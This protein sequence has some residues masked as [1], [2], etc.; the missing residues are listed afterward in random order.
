MGYALTTPYLENRDDGWQLESND[1]IGLLIM[2]VA[3]EF[4][5]LFF[6]KDS[7]S[8]KISFNTNENK[9]IHPSHDY[10]LSLFLFQKIQTSYVMFFSVRIL[11]GRGECKVEI[12]IEFA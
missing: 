4:I 11:Q 1:F 9:V 12:V 2:G 3:G 10:G 7:Q 8:L 6:L 5:A